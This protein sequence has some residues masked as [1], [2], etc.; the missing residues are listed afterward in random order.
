MNRKLQ[1]TLVLASITLALLLPVGCGR[2]GAEP[3]PTPTKTPVP[4]AGDAAPAG[5]G[6]A[7][8]ATPV[9]P[10]APADQGATAPDQTESNPAPAQ[11]TTKTVARIATSILNVRT[12][13]N[14]EAQLAQ[15]VDE[16]QEFDVIG[17]TEGDVW[18]QLG[19]AGRELGWVAGE[20]VELRQ[21]DLAVEPEP[22]EPPAGGGEGQQA[23]GRPAWRRQLPARHH[24]QSR[25]RRAGLSLVA[26]G[27]RR[28]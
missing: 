25:L 14:A 12:E 9:P 5:D 4:A 18:I 27:D 15:T 24:A 11:P 8:T 26:A 10:A 17:R 2:G 21:V 20:F 23:V 1:R 7:A 13:P 6:A 28:P 22:A 3:T 19:E 16:G